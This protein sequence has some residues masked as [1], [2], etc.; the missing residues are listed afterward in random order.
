MFLSMD[1]SLNE[2]F[3]AI[4]VDN[5][6]EGAIF[7]T[8]NGVIRLRNNIK[9][10]EATGHKLY[11][12]NNA[13]VEYETGLENTNFSSGPGGSWEVVSWQEIE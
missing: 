7:Y 1:S 12:D 2:E 6:A 5:N 11:L 8:V 9:I 13:I 4:D 10:R 3:A